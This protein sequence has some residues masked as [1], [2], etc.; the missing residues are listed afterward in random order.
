MAKLQ[1]HLGLLRE[2]Y[3]KLQQRLADFES[4][5]QVALAASGQT[6]DNSFVSKLLQTVADLFEKDRYR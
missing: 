1:A 4:K 3:V 6:K 5:Y 2:E